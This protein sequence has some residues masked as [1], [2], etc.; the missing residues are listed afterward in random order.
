MI[1]T[2]R[3]LLSAVASDPV[4]AEEVAEENLTNALITCITATMTACEAQS[5]AFRHV[6]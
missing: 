3:R 1:G 2:E 6:P 4:G 5:A